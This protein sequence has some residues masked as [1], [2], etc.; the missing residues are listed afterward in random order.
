MDNAMGAE[1]S[2]YLACLGSGELSC[3][4][5]EDN[6]KES[7][8]GKW[9]WCEKGWRC[10]QVPFVMFVKARRQDAQNMGFTSAFVQFYL[11]QVKF[12]G[13]LWTF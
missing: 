8:P 3:I 5:E 2:A 9:N 10:Q 12:C 7:F 6:G 1:R 4:I 13:L 11:G